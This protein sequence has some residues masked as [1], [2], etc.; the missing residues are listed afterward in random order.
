[1][2]ISKEVYD[3]IR[4]GELIYHDGELI[5][6]NLPNISFMDRYDGEVLKKDIEKSIRAIFDTDVEL[7]LPDILNRVKLLLKHFSYKDTDFAWSIVTDELAER[8]QVHCSGSQIHTWISVVRN[9]RH[10]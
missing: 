9:L 7:P 2:K 5:Q 3:K 8:H 4:S 10:I 6:G 1:M